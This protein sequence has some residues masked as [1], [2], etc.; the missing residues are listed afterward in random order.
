MN[1]KIIIAFV[2]EAGAGKDTC[3][4]LLVQQLKE[5]YDIDTNFI[6]SC[7]TRPKRQNEEDGVDYHFLTIQQ[8][9]E[10]VLNGDMLESTS[11][12]DWF[13]GTAYSDLADGINIGVFNPAGIECLLEEQDKIILIGYYIKCSDKERLIRQ[14]NREDSPDINEI[15]RRY[16]TDKEDFFDIRSLN[17]I[18]KSN[19]NYIEQQDLVDEICQ[20]VLYL[21][22]KL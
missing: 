10:R 14:L 11:F 4:R 6:V 5:K 20:D 21:V 8:F 13:Y 18:E 12:N 7:T 15:I 3:A 22:K 1:K 16:K 19:E 9:G 2:G 17:L